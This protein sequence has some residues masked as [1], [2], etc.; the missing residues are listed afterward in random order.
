MDADQRQ[1][2]ESLYLE[3]Y[4]KLIIYANCAF[5]EEGLAEEAVQETFRI[6]CQKADQ[7]CDSENPRGWLVNTLKF[8][9]RNMRRSRE[10][11]QQLLS[12]YLA[13]QTEAITYSTDTVSLEVLYEDMAHSEEFKLVKEMAV[14]GKSHLQMAEARGITV[15]ACKKRMERAKKLLQKKL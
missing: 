3:M 2:I 5:P 11:G 13:L 1:F 4:P 6:A 12:R 8:T 14:D 7:I 15:A 10:S 9:I